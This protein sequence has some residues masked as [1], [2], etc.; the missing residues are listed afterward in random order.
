MYSIKS[1]GRLLWACRGL[2]AL[3]AVA[4]VLINVLH[5]WVFS[6][7]GWAMFLASFPPAFVI[8][9]AEVI[10]RAPIAPNR[11][12][13][14]RW[15]RPSA[16]VGLAFGGAYLSYFAQRDV[17]YHYSKSLS[18]AR[19]LPLLVDGFVLIMSMTVYEINERRAAMDTARRSQ[20]AGEVKP[21]PQRRKGNSFTAREQVAV[22]L[23]KD[24][25]L[26]PRDLANR[27]GISAGYASTLA[28]ELRP[29]LNGSELVTVE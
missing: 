2:I 17:I 4:S 6:G 8:T 14:R 21:T 22:L 27:V 10:S 7:N 24:P 15:I 29:E 1:L 25:N 18:E 28:K 3:A 5:G 13:L 11:N 23:S 16:M 12:W 19:I 26:S 20:E 9:S